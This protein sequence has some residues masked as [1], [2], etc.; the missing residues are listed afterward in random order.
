M[1]RLFGRPAFLLAPAD[2]WPPQA[3]P[4]TI[5][6]SEADLALLGKPPSKWTRD[7]WRHYAM[8]LLDAGEAIAKDLARTRKALEQARKKASRKPKVKSSPTAEP[9]HVISFLSRIMEPRKKAG[10]R[11]NDSTRER[12]AEALAIRDELA[13]STKKKRISYTQ[14]LEEWYRSR[15]KLR[16]ERLAADDKAA[17][18]EMSVQ[19][20]NNRRS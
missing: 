13:R 16:A 19:S 10:R 2:L 14:A 20:R 8:R 3:P 7:D 6:T 9:G 18:R 4:T 5:F 1:R 11:K 17:L 15:G 12:A